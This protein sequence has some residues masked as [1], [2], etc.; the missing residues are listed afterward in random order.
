VL[1]SENNKLK[2]SMFDKVI[3]KIVISLKTY[4]FKKKII[5]QFLDP[6]PLSILKL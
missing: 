6:D 2:I 4:N 5:V 3:I 1:T